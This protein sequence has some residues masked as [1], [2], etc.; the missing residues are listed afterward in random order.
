MITFDDAR[1]PTD[2]ERQHLAR[3]MY[4]AFCDLRIL[5]MN[6]QQVQQSHDLADAF[7]NV[8][9]LMYRED[10]SF[11]AFREF[12]ERYQQQYEGKLLTNYLREWEK[13]NTAAQ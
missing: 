9:L 3:L 10:F 12:L 8:P 11:R 1:L 4:L 6:P 13:L 2:L 5:T 7:H